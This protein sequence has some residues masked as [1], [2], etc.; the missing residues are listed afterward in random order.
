MGLYRDSSGVLFI[1]VHDAGGVYRGADRRAA[2]S[3]H[4]TVRTGEAA[5]D[6][7]KV[8]VLSGALSLAAALLAA[9]VP[10]AVPVLAILLGGMGT[11]LC[12][13]LG[14]QAYVRWRLVG[15]ALAARLSVALLVY[16]A[17]VV[18]LATTQV[19]GVGGSL[20]QT[21]GT[22]AAGAALLTTIGS[23]EVDGRVQFLRPVGAVAVVAAVA[24]ILPA[25]HPGAAETI[26]AL[27]ILRQPA[28][29]VAATAVL[30]AAAGVLTAVGLRRSRRILTRAGASFAVLVVV[31]SVAAGGP[32]PVGA[33]L[34]AAAI[35]LGALALMVPTAIADTRLALFAVGRANR[36]LRNRWRDAQ[37]QVDGL[38]REDAERRHEIRSALLAIEGASAVL[39]R[40]FEHLGRQDEA[41]LA[42]AVESEITRLQQLVTRSPAPAPGTYALRAALQ[43]VV[44][45]HRAN[46][47]EV[48]L[49]IPPD[50]VVVGRP[51]CLVEAVGNLLV[52]AAVHAPGA[53]VRIATE[54]SAQPHFVRLVVRDDGPGLD[55]VA[56][57][58]VGRAAHGE[59][60]AT[61]P[62]ADG[63]G[64]GLP[65][66][67]RLVS[68]DGGRLSL[69]ETA[70]RRH[71]T[72]I[73]MDL[74]LPPDA[75]RIESADATGS[76]WT[77]NAS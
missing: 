3:A 61:Q 26:L 70:G 41:E 36:G 68:Q 60:S 57:A 8:L 20:A 53:R 77:A 6:A 46:G 62:G 63:P 4:V 7:T 22:I 55:P 49:D 69:V 18:P 33:P 30:V 23:P 75:G 14:E 13:I 38:A 51:V 40:N 24:A 67:A 19:D 44:L 31:P 39:R 72:T 43:P 34:V 45:A 56:A 15:D 50:T 58:R 17:T 9:D 5:V 47:L 64:L 1:A 35:Q 71:G 32:T 25:P 73:V 12:F 2:P 54:A 16:G 48:S 42:A 37:A 10:R 11:G 59:A 74:Q 21:A 28:V 27:T 65:L 52:N 66:A 29:E 76:A